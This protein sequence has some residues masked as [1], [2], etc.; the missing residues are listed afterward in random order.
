MV[1]ISKRE[2][3]EAERQYQMVQR[4]AKVLP[5]GGV[6]TGVVCREQKGEHVDRS[7]NARGTYQNSTHQCETDGQLSI[8]HEKS[9]CRSMWQYKSLEHWNHKRVSA[10][11]DKAVDPKLKPAPKSE[12]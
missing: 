11:V 9:D 1:G 2:S 7:A 12:L 10:I 6:R 3:R 4:S 8:G 5:E